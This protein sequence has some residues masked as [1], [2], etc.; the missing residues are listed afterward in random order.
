MWTC[1][2]FALFTKASMMGVP[3][4]QTQTPHCYFLLALLSHCEWSHIQT[5]VHCAQMPRTTFAL[6]TA[7]NSAHK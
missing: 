3:T 1:V 6:S 7:A 2:R 5:T 4:Q